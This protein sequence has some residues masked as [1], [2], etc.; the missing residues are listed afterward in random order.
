MGILQIKCKFKIFSVALNFGLIF[1]TFVTL[2]LFTFIGCLFCTFKAF[3]RSGG[4]PGGGNLGVKGA[5]TLR[6][7]G[8][9]KAGSG[10]PRRQEFKP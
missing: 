8:E 9:E 3:T 7:T 5:G 2:I 10:I 4:R 1:V 6:A